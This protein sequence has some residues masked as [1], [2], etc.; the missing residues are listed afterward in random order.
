LGSVGTHSIAVTQRRNYGE[1]ERLGVVAMSANGSETRVLKAVEGV[2]T[3]D[4]Y[5]VSLEVGDEIAIESGQ[6]TLD[7]VIQSYEQRDSL[8]QG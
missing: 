3:A 1:E 6:W 7:A 4:A 2:E 8:G 5:A